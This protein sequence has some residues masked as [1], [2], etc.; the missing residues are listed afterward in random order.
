MHFI[1]FAQDLV[2][3]E[4]FTGSLRFVACGQAAGNERLLRPSVIDADP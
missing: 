3:R 4:V 1:Q 2:G